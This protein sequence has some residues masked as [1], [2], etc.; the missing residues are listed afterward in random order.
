M[1]VDL[2]SDRGYE[3]GG[4]GFMR[5]YADRM[6]T[7]TVSELTGSWMAASLL[8]QNP[9]YTPS[10]ER[11][12]GAR[13]RRALGGVVIGRKDSGEPCL[14]TSGLAGMALGAGAS[15]AWHRSSDRSAR[16][17]FIALGSLAGL[18]AVANL[19]REFFRRE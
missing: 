17:Y 5:R 19:S 6:G 12:F 13:A 14:N 3:M 7:T 1:A 4:T 9:R 10:S 2:Q 15:T 11:G 18:K 8:R 16:N